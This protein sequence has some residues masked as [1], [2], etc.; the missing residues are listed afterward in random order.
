MF[1]PRA[2]PRPAPRADVPTPGKDWFSVVPAPCDERRDFC[3]VLPTLPIGSIRAAA[4]SGEHDVGLLGDVGALGT[5]TGQGTT[6]ASRCHSGSHRH[7]VQAARWERTSRWA[8]AGYDT[9][10]LAWARLSV[11]TIASPTKATALFG[12]P[13]APRRSRTLTSRARFGARQT[14]SDGDSRASWLRPVPSSSWRL[15]VCVT[16]VWPNCDSLA[17]GQ[18]LT[19]GVRTPDVRGPESTQ[20]VAQVPQGS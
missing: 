15:L 14:L 18:P 1:S 12:T 11:M 16:A 6:P 19:L 17:R 7:Q 4:L 8:D 3:S 20:A 13:T 9:T 2:T 10:R 5:P